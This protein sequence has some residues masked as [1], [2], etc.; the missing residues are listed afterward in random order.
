MQFLDSLRAIV[1]SVIR[2]SN[3]NLYKMLFLLYLFVLLNDI[4][5]LTA[6]ED[7]QSLFNQYLI[8]LPLVLSLNAFFQPQQ[9]YF[10]INIP[11]Y[12][13]NLVANY[14]ADNQVS[15]YLSDL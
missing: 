6:T 7:S 3:E 14:V 10:P 11:F 9:T 5:E 15:L 4:C 12:G 13:S 2:K 8:S 1:T